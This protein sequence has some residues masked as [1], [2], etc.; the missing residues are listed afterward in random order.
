MA[1]LVQRF[2]ERLAGIRAS[3]VKIQAYLA[4]GRDS[5]E[6]A[7]HALSASLA[8][9]A[10]LEIVWQLTEA[11][12]RL[13]SAMG[14]VRAVSDRLTRYVADIGIPASGRWVPDQETGITC[15]EVIP[16]WIRWNLSPE[17]LHLD[18]D[19]WMDASRPGALQVGL[20]HPVRAFIFWLGE[21][22]RRLR[23]GHAGPE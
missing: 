3:L 12:Q 14:A 4:H 5:F 7:R 11:E 1:S 9:S 23:G 10:T 22:R 19:S 17:Y 13:N 6:D 8:T 15:Q 16:E 2:G 21:R 18:F 20:G